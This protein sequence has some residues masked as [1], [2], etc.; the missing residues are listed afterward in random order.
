MQ[1][2]GGR[3]PPYDGTGGVNTY[4]YTYLIGYHYGLHVWIIQIK[5]DKD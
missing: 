2:W 5:L 1:G 3:R 4:A